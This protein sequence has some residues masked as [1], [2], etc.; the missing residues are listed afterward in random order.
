M[1]TSDRAQIA[2]ESRIEEQ[3][4]AGSPEHRHADAT[5]AREQPPEPAAGGTT[6]RQ[7]SL[8]DDLSHDSWTEIMGE[9]TAPAVDADA[10]SWTESLA[11]A[12]GL[13]A[14]FII[15]ACVLAGIGLICL[16][17]AVERAA[18]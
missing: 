15:A 10:P 7:P 8:L 13:V 9:P 16:W 11:S 5:D 1:S 12:R 18:R 2:T 3:V 14:G 4:E 6:R 17:C